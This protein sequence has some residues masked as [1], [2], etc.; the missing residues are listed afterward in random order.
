MIVKNESAVIR[1]CLDSVRPFIHTWAIV[2]TGSTDGTQDIIREHLRGVPGELFERPW[3]DFGTNRSEAIELARAHGSHLLIL[4]ADEVLV[5][6]PKFVMPPLTAD[7]YQLKTTLGDFSYY[8]TQ[9]VATALPWR[10]VGVLHE[11]LECDRPFRQ[12][13]LEGLVNHPAPDG[14]RSADPLKFEKDAKI[15]EEALRK[16]PNNARYV[17][18]LAQSLRDAGQHEAAIAPYDRRATMGGWV[19]E[20][21]V[22]RHEA[23]R[24]RELAGRAHAEVVEA[25][26]SAYQARPTRAESLCALARIYRQR[27]EFDLAYLF[28]RQACA[29]RR[30]NDT[31]FVD[32]SVYAWRARDEQSVAAYYLGKHDEVV[33][34]T[35]ALLAEGNLPP[36]QVDRVRRNRDLSL[37][38]RKKTVGARSA[39]RR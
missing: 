33:A 25:Y 4:D 18:Y 14:A 24:A 13:R 3:R 12:E 38:A 37:A 39:R 23:A 11:Y 31:L 6:A 16:E 34:L 5:P 2:D 17:F 27:N 32:D 15:L 9:I 22:A 8:R 7:A 20:V 26:L 29:I 28:A 21:Y 19:E 30:P 35:N 10:W 36:D 1:R